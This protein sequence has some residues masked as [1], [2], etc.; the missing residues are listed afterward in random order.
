MADQEQNRSEDATPFKL[1]KAREKGNVARGTDLGFFSALVAFLL[2]LGL[3]GAAVAAKLLTILRSGFS[4]FAGLDDPHAVLRLV[5][6]DASLGLGILVLLGLTLLVVVAPLEVLQ[7]KGL[8]FS[9]QPLKPD[10][11]RLN[12]A[13]GLKRLFS[14]RMLKEALK[15]V[16][17]FL[18]YAMLAGLCIRYAVTRSGYQATGAGQLA[19]LMW[20][21]GLRLL[22]FF[23]AAALLFAGIDQVLARQVVV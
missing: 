8:V 1:A 16:L 6:Q 7:V 15:S 14:L 9:A 12:P 21:S 4:S 20:Q 2:F 17:K 23:A 22:T 19:G 10:F 18:L 11:G 13:K 3:A 5:G